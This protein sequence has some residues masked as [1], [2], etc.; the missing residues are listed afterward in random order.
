MFER[1]PSESLERFA[2]FVQQCLSIVKCWILLV[3]LLSVGGLSM[4]KIE[5]KKL[6][7]RRVLNFRCQWSLIDLIGK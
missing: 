5:S 2:P 7:M 1:N 6:A 3:S 4:S